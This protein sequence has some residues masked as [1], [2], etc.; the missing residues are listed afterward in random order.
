MK[1]NY[2]KLIMMVERLRSIFSAT[3]SVELDRMNI[4]DL[5]NVQS[6][7]LYS[8]GDGCISVA[9]IK[10]KKHYSGS[11]VSYNLRIMVENGYLKQEQCEHDLRINYVKLSKK[12]FKLYEKLDELFKS[13]SY[14]LEQKGISKSNLDDILSFGKHLEIFWG[15][16]KMYD[17]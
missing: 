3:M 14:D 12:G 1:E 13:H 11:N 2:F 6:I 10:N 5:T 15:N 8:I 4:R 16:L 9:D 17:I 7:L